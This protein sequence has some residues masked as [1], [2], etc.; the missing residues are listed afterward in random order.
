MHQ[1]SFQIFTFLFPDPSC[2][3]VLHDVSIH[4]GVFSPLF[5]AFCKKRKPTGLSCR[6]KLLLCWISNMFEDYRVDMNKH[7][8]GV[9]SQHRQRHLCPT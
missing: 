9:L 4:D 7:P 1:G 6:L 3:S 2:T 8:V 5:A